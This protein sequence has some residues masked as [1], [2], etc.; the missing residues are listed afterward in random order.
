MAKCV[1][2]RRLGQ[3]ADH[4]RDGQRERDRNGS[5]GADAAATKAAAPLPARVSNEPPV[6]LATAGPVAAPYPAYPQ[7]V[8]VPSCPNAGSA[9]PAAGLYFP[10]HFCFL[11]S[12]HTAV[13]EAIRYAPPVT[14]ATPTAAAAGPWAPAAAVHGS[15]Q[16]STAVQALSTNAPVAA[17]TAARD[18]VTDNPPVSFGAAGPAVT[19]CPTGVQGANVASGANVGTAYGA[20]QF[21]FAPPCHAAV[22]TGN[23][24]RLA[25]QAPP[26]VA[27]ARPVVQ[28]H[29]T[30]PAAASAR[31]PAVHR[32]KHR[33]TAVVSGRASAKEPAPV[34]SRRKAARKRET[35]SGD[36]TTGGSS[37]SS[38]VSSSPSQ[39]VTEASSR[40]EEQYG[41]VGKKDLLKMMRTCNL[42]Q[43][44]PEC[45]SRRRRLV[46]SLMGV[47]A[48]VGALAMT[49]GLLAVL[50][51]S[52]QH[53]FT[54]TGVD[55][56]AN[57]NS[58]NGEPQSRRGL[59]EGVADHGVQEYELMPN[60][61]GPLP[62]SQMGPDDF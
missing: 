46:T 22:G 48:L 60:E 57:A 32:G 33:S 7:G 37:A 26:V 6:S 54:Q 8:N 58:T 31:K 40:E 27:A 9:L 3:H 51:D 21:D 20:P 29:P 25:A 5:Q 12:G 4:K 30:V 15:N 47:A 39:E 35:D 14:A 55:G 43:P 53:G 36:A 41:W 16:R 13:G 23:A 45:G 17:A 59:L 56:E 1:K 44:P 2:H 24:H 62:R 42:P 28:G 49:A 18:G 11:P 38:S 52:W 10:P 50:K 34:S 19:P 61:Y